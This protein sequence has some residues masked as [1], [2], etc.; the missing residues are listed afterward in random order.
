MQQNSG[1]IGFNSGMADYFSRANLPSQREML[2]SVVT[3]ILRSGVT[4]NRKA[5]CLRLIARLD[6]ASSV[7]E[8]HELQALIELLFSK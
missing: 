4:L 2:G 7:E 8:E 5:I 6:N 3:E 1:S